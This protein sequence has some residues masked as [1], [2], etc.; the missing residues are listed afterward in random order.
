MKVEM[1]EIRVFHS[2]YSIP[3]SKRY[4][5]WHRRRLPQRISNTPAELPPCRLD[6][7]F[8]LE[9]VFHQQQ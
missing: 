6:I 1:D 4:L 2:Y 3:K 7:I 5:C 9:M 8:D